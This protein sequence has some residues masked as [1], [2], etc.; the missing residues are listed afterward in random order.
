MCVFMFTLF[1]RMIECNTPAGTNSPEPIELNSCGNQHQSDIKTIH[2]N[3]MPTTNTRNQ[4]LNVH[5]DTTQNSVIDGEKSS[6]L[7]TDELD[8][9]KQHDTQCIPV[10]KVNDIEIDSPTKNRT[11]KLLARCIFPIENENNYTRGCLFSPD[12][13]CVLSYND[14]NTVRIFEPPQ[15]PAKLDNLTEKDVNIKEL[16]AAVTVPISGPIYDVNWYP[17]MNSSDPVTCCFAVTAQ[18]Q[19]VHLYDAYDGHLRAT[20]RYVITV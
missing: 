17:L 16:N 18:C 2:S 8:V 15:E 13:L 20:Y 19:P 4:V 12:G 6:A 1:Y 14:D 11:K 3:I 10:D 7:N 5:S 9:V